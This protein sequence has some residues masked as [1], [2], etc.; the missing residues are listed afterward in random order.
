MGRR[1]VGV[2]RGTLTQTLTYQTAGVRDGDAGHQILHPINADGTSV[3]KLGSTVPTKFRV[4]DINRNS[5]GPNSAFSSV[6]QSYILA[7]KNGTVQGSIDESHYSNTPDT[8]FRWD[9][10]AQQWIYNISTK[11]APVNVVNTTYYF[12]IDLNDGT[13]IWFN[14]GLK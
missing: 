11:T 8:A 12:R 9:P 2:I 5:V 4:C 7:G 10:T 14:F 1:R 6:V 13:S 3:W